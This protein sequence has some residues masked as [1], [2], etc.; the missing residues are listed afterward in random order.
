[1]EESRLNNAVPL[2]EGP[3]RE[4][5]TWALVLTPRQLCEGPPYSSIN[6]GLCGHSTEAQILP[7]LIPLLSPL[8]QVL[9]LRAPLIYSAD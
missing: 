3:C 9:I 7:G 4:M 8:S 5:K 6:R 2:P 1:M